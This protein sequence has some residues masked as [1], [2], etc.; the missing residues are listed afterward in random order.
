MG[1]R[2]VI[3]R[4]RFGKFK[5]KKEDQ[6]ELLEF[7]NKYFDELSIQIIGNKF[8]EFKEVMNYAL[9]NYS[10]SIS[11][12]IDTKFGIALLNQIFNY[13]KPLPLKNIRWIYHKLTMTYNTYNFLS[14]LIKK[15]NK[16]HYLVDCSR[17]SGLV[18][19]ILNVR[20]FSTLVLLK[21]LF[22]FDGLCLRHY[23]PVKNKDGKIIGYSDDYVWKLNSET[24]FYERVKDKEFRLNRSSEYEIM[25]NLLS[26]NKLKIPILAEIKKNLEQDQKR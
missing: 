14:I 16:K 3:P 24:F 10:K 13:L 21:E 25:N 2:K 17:R 12:V 22:D 5:P 1:Y 15:D 23:F 26:C 11:P 8:D 9:S 7:Q 19:K 4:F 18:F 20:D 6:I